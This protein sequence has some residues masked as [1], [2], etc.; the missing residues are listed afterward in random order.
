MAVW[1]LDSR[2][3]FRTGI[4]GF[5]FEWMARDLLRHQRIPSRRVMGR[6]SVRG[7]V[8]NILR[9]LSLFGNSGWSR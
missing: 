7:M 4:V 5:G 8:N 6:V 1:V 2:Y 9:R 3:P